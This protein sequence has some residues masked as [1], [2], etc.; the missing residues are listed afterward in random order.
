MNNK[1]IIESYFVSL[2]FS[3]DQKKITES[4]EKLK[5]T[6][7]GMAN[8][9]KNTVQ[10]INAT[11]KSIG[12][13][14]LKGS[15]IAL[16]A[17]FSALFLSIKKISNLAK[18]DLSLTI[19]AKKM[20]MPVA[21]ARRLRFALDELK[22][23]AE[24][25]KLNP[26]LFSQYKQL[27]SDSKTFEASLGFEKQMKQVR[28]FYFEFSRLRQLFRYGSYSIAEGLLKTFGVPLEKLT[29]SFQ[30]LN[31]IAMNSFPLWRVWTER[32]ARPV[33]DFTNILIKNGL[34]ALKIFGTNTENIFKK[35]FETI[36]GIKN[37]ILLVFGL[38]EDFNKWHAG[39]DSVLGP[40]WEA[41]TKKIKEAWTWIVQTGKRIISDAKNL[42]LDM[43]TLLTE[44]TTG[45]R[46]LNMAL[47]KGA[48][49]MAK[50]AGFTEQITE[51][52]KLI[53]GGIGSSI[54][55]SGEREREKK[56][57]EKMIKARAAERFS[58]ANK[59]KY[60]TLQ[61]FLQK[62]GNFDQFFFD[63][64][65]GKEEVEQLKKQYNAFF[66]QEKE[67]VLKARQRALNPFVSRIQELGYSDTIEKYIKEQNKKNKIK[68][69]PEE[70]FAFLQTEN[71]ALNPN[72]VS[73][74]GD[75]G[76]M[77]IN[78]GAWN[79]SRKEL[80]NP[81][82]NLKKGIE[83]YAALRQKYDME[84]AV[85]NYNRGE[86]SEFDNSEYWN[87]WLKN[88]KNILGEKRTYDI[89][90][91]KQNNAIS[92]GQTSVAMAVNAINDTDAFS[93]KTI[94]KKYG[95]N[96]FEALTSETKNK[97]TWRDENFSGANWP[98]Y[99]KRVKQAPLIMGLGGQ[100]SPSGRGHII[101]VTG[102]D[103]DKVTYI[104]PADGRTK[105]TTKRTI[106]N[107]K[108]HPD[109]KFVF[110]GERI[111]KTSDAKNLTASSENRFTINGGI[112]V[113]VSGSNS[114]ARDIASATADALESR[115][116]YLQASRAISAVRAV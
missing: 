66:R 84:T 39:A 5:K 37:P 60:L 65:Y 6:L 88:F 40:F 67:K 38:L 35:V 103:G 72:V 18:E 15:L 46:N 45:I 21:A 33:R 102:I 50:I 90:P 53:N 59:N 108:P 29:K 30:N 52:W 42:S 81:G 9:I 114:N 25:V 96:L 75:V 71:A 48:A 49:I 94:N 4:V 99:E 93:D 13:T 107:A 17:G 106:E 31:K 2:G 12:G 63:S 70:I 92:C 98:Q 10:T 110:S 112:N 111:Q 97:I 54:V 55:A 115:I 62:G 28:G 101:T 8:A 89:K 23:S 91:L 16:T 105:T 19:F 11:L 47:E 43:K 69:K 78:A 57:I 116:K 20:A 87:K 1:N 61:T 36:S 74:T 24:D 73:N 14:F 26:E 100:F 82:F 34:D 44:G 22:V 79:L 95:F 32:L 113:Y 51:G 83:I 64:T 58:R 3:L 80:Q 77:Q 56:D 7:S 86:Y 68:I 104:D 109:G 85:R 76:L 41:L 27:L